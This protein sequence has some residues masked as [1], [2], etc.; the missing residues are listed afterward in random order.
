MLNVAHMNN[1][2]LLLHHIPSNCLGLT[3]QCLD[4][5][6]EAQGKGLNVIGEF[7]PYTF[8]GTSVTGTLAGILLQWWTN[9]ID[10]PYLISGKPLFSLPANIPVTFEIIVLSSVW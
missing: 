2:P 8:A 4:L 5:I 10:Y 1:V 6:E 9:A 7:Y 3:T